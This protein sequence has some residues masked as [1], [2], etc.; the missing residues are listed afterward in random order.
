M[1][2]IQQS[3]V[4]SYLGVTLTANGIATFSLLQQPMQD[5]ID[6]YCNRSWNL[7]NPVVEDFDALTSIGDNLVANYTFFPKNS[8]SPTV[9]NPTYPLAKGIISVVIGTSPLDMNYVVSYGTHLKISATFPS[10]ILTNP[11]G[12][13]MVHVTYNADLTL[14]TPIKAAMAQWMARM[15]QEA[16]DAG[17]QTYEVS[18]GT[19]KVQ[20]AASRLNSLQVIPDFVKLVLDKYRLPAVDHF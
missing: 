3:D 11:L 10:V 6:W 16:P 18:A 7:T 9:A 12:F 2:Y 14:P 19:V 15:I 4:E 5:L 8:I 13:K 17:K 20:Y 1:N